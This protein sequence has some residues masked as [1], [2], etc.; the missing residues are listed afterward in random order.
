[1]YNTKHHPSYSS[2][3]KNQTSI[4]VKTHLQ[5]ALTQKLVARA[6]RDLNHGSQLGHLP[7]DIVL[8]VRDALEI[9]NELLDDRLPRD[10]SFNEDVRRPKV[11]RRDVLLDERLATRDC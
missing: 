2:S 6:K 11:V 8:D 10:E 7:R 9:C 1:M 4:D 3:T 5:P